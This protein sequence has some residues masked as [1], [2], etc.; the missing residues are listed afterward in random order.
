MLGSGASTSTKTTAPSV[1]D[2][3]GY[4]DTSLDTSTNQEL[5]SLNVS[6]LINS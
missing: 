3:S 5:S 1:S 6:V 2:A 4:A